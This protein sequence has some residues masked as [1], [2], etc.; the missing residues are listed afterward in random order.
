[1][2]GQMSKWQ[3]GTKNGM[4]KGGKTITEHDYVLVR[5]GTDHHL[6]DVRGYAYEHRLVAEHKF[7]RRLKEGEKVHHIDGDRK[8]NNPDN[9]HICK[10][11]AQHLFIHRKPDSNLQI[12]SESNNIIQC[13]CGCGS[14]FLK[15]DKYK[16]PRQ[17]VSGHNIHPQPKNR[18]I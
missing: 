16:R 15:F 7:G 18:V 6:S 13:K 1:M 3:T 5:V 2:D 4:W 17:F 11:M 14:E 12:P 10:N 8:N 9:I